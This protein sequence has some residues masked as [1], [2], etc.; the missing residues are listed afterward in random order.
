MLWGGTAEKSREQ[1]STF[2]LAGLA[3]RGVRLHVARVDSAWVARA[4]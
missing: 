1:E 3:S 4:V 2:F